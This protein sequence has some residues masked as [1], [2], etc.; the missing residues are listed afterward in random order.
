MKSRD[1]WYL[2]GRDIIAGTSP[3]DFLK[4]QGNRASALEGFF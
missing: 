3:G 4:I 2:A 1:C